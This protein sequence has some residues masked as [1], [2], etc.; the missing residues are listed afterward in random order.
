MQKKK[1]EILEIAQNIKH[2]V[3]RFSNFSFFSKP[4]NCVYFKKK[5]L[6]HIINKDFYFH[7]KLKLFFV[8]NNE[9]WEKLNQSLHKNI[10]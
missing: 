4:Q 6:L 10:T 7:F 3:F 9:S 2:F 1:S 8:F 5:K